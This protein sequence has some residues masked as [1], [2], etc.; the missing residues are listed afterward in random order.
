M[1]LTSGSR[2]TPRSVG[3]DSELDR[4]DGARHG[5]DLRR[6]LARRTTTTAAPAGAGKPPAAPRSATNAPAPARRCRTAGSHR[7]A[8]RRS[9]RPSS[10]AGL[11]RPAPVTPAAIAVEIAGSV[12]RIEIRGR[13]SHEARPF[14]LP[15]PSTMP[16]RSSRMR[17]ARPHRFQIVKKLLTFAVTRLTT[18]TKFIECRP[19]R[20]D[21]IRNRNG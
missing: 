11:D 16:A 3:W 15:L 2:A 7:A 5:I 6:G 10:V 8:S 4:P 20:R 17:D 19:G 9:G 18:M 21:A 12:D 14:L 13:A 1:S